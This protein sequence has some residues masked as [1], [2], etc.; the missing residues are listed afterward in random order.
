M[1]A[2]P[3][4]AR[5]KTPEGDELEPGTTYRACPFNN[6]NIMR[7]AREGHGLSRVHIHATDVAKAP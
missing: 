1:A 4:R 6:V 5:A 7:R 3:H 2:G